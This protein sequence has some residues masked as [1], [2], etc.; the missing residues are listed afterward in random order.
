[1]DCWY[2]QTIGKLD[3]YKL[4]KLSQGRSVQ[5]PVLMLKVLWNVA[6]RHN[7]KLWVGRNYHFRAGVDMDL[8]IPPHLMEKYRRSIACVSF[9]QTG[10][11]RYL[12]AFIMRLFFR[13]YMSAMVPDV[14]AS[15]QH[16]FYDTAVNSFLVFADGD[17]AEKARGNPSGFP[18]TLRL[19]CVCHLIIYNYIFVQLLTESSVVLPTTSQVLAFHRDHVFVEICGDDSR[20]FVLSAFGKATL[21]AHEEW[22]RLHQAWQVWP[23]RGKLEGSYIWEKHFEDLTVSELLRIPPFISRKIVKMDGFYWQVLASPNRSA[24]RLL[25]SDDLDPYL[26]RELLRSYA[27][28][29]AHLLWWHSQGEAFVLFFEGL[30][31]WLPDHYPL[32]VEEASVIYANR[33]FRARCIGHGPS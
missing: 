19:N 2:W 3:G 17:M 20:I 10:W 28:A 5:A 14:P 33:Y 26:F 1:M 7:D 11:D 16:F 32:M 23:W 9:D 8:C 13:N 21:G 27:N 4:S 31:L 22:G 6:Y 18:N 12:P 25:H 24:K 29:N 15:L 30:K